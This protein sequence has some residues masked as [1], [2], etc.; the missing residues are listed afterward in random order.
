MASVKK[1]IMHEY[2][3][4]DYDTLYPK[5]I[6]SQVDGVYNKT[7]ID[8]LLKK[9]VG[10]ESTDYPGCYYRTVN[11]ITEWLNP[12]MAIGVEYRTTERNIGKP[13]YVKTLDF[14]ALPNNASKT[15]STGFKDWETMPLA[16]D[17]YFYSGADRHNTPL[18]TNLSVKLVNF[19]GTLVTI[20]TNF[21]A[22][23][24]NAYVTT[25]YTKD[26]D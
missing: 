22:S 14:G 6:A 10:I 9:A 18:E 8:T 21:N 1:I 3:G 25:K 12:P 5:T 23:S 17:C 24:Y 15:V 16:A 13:V 7:E 11:G 26:A 4:T 19:N 20:T 2:N